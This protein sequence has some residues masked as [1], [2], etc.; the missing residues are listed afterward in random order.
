M[1]VE[2]NGTMNIIEY[3]IKSLGNLF[4]HFNNILYTTRINKNVNIVYL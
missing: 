1:K 4:L 2:I 3:Y